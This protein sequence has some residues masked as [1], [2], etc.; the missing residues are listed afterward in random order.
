MFGI[1]ER[2]PDSA[3]DQNAANQEQEIVRPRN[4]AGHGEDGEY[5]NVA[6]ECDKNNREPNPT[7][8]VSLTLHGTRPL[9]QRSS[10]EIV[11]EYIT[12]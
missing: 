10:S 7:K 6:Y 9:P 3:G 12:G 8:N 1:A 11:N 4:V 2:A 5:G